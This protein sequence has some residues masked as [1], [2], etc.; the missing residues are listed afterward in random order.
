MSEKNVI[1]AEEK[2]ENGKEERPEPPKDENGNPMM[3]PHG[4]KPGE[5]K[6]E[7]GTAEKPAEAE[8]AEV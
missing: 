4:K 3:P 6:T 8:T 2:N 5:C 7:E 1:E